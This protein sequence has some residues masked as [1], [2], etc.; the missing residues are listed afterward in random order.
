LRVSP[1]RFPILLLAIRCLLGAYMTSHYGTE[2]TVP[3]AAERPGMRRKLRRTAD[4][5]LTSAVA[6]LTGLSP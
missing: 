6:M 4:D 3:A 5:P 2:R 1:T